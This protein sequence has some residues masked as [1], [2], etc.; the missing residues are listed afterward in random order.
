MF[1]R[2]K[3]PF[4]EICSK[5]ETPKG[6]R[7]SE[8]I[9]EYHYTDCS[10]HNVM[11]LIYITKKGPPHADNFCDFTSRN[12]IFLKEITISEAKKLKFSACGG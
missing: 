11:Y 7:H 1:G 2:K 12:A 3:I 9:R 8:K 5:M 4:D 6:R 10:V